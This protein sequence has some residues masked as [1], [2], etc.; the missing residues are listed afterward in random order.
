MSA[1]GVIRLMKVMKTVMFIQQKLV[2][3]GGEG[4]EGCEGY[5]SD[6]VVEV[7]RITRITGHPGKQHLYHRPP[8]HWVQPDTDKTHNC[9]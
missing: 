8:C 4:D 9:L 1:V 2:Y 6:E 3:E 5:G 7:M